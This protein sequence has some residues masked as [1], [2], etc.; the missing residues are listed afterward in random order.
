MFFLPFVP[1]NEL[2]SCKHEK[3]KKSQIFRILKF[4]IYIFFLVEIIKKRKIQGAYPER[5]FL[6]VHMQ[7][8]SP[9]YVQPF[10]TQPLYGSSNWRK[11]K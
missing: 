2:Q 8:N 1:G 5:T 10:W 3:V 6:G 4:N 7:K 11:K 9:A